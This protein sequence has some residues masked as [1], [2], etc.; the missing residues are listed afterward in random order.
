MIKEFVTPTMLPMFDAFPVGIAVLDGRYQPTYAN[1]LAKRLWV[2][3]AKLEFGT[4]SAVA[5]AFAESCRIE[6]G[7]PFWVARVVG[8]RPGEGLVVNVHAGKSFLRAGKRYLPFV[9]VPV[10]GD[11]WEH[12]G[13]GIFVFGHLRVD[14]GSATVMYGRQYLDV[15]AKEFQLM[16]FIVRHPSQL[17][18]KERILRDVWGIRTLNTRTLDMT[19]SRLRTKLRGVGCPEDALRTVHGQGFY[20][21]PSPLVSSSPSSASAPSLLS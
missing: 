13:E 10:A 18:A 20:F 9:L 2:E 16:A 6:R 3:A 14:L 12:R 17:L 11:P 15:S 4:Q 5:N 7:K 21:D 8:N 1:R 19:M